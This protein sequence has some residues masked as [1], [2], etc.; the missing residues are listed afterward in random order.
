MTRDGLRPWPELDLA[1]VD[2]SPQFVRPENVQALLGATTDTLKG[3]IDGG[4][5]LIGRCY[6]ALGYAIN[7]TLVAFG[8]IGISSGAVSKSEG[9]MIQPSIT[10]GFAAAAFALL[11][12]S[13]LIVR[14]IIPLELSGYGIHARQFYNAKLLCGDLRSLQMEIIQLFGDSAAEN[15]ETLRKIR[16]RLQ[17]ALLLIILSPF[18]GV[19][20]WAVLKHARLTSS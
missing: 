16:L 13:L 15:R 6:I 11:I 17:F 2:G 18:F 3:Q 19:A 12:S 9:W 1:A 4:R 7:L 14:N 5:L 8:G 10:W 20:A